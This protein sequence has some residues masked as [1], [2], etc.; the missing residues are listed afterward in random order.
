MYVLLILLYSLL[1]LLVV[2][3]N[4]GSQRKLL[5]PMIGVKTLTL[6]AVGAGIAPMIKI[7]RHIFQLPNDENMIEVVLLYGAVSLILLL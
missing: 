5:W 6:L 3:D 7:L 2:T 1:I 4:D